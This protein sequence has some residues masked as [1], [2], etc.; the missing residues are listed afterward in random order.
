[1]KPPLVEPC[2]FAPGEE[3]ALALDC[4]EFCFH[5]IET[6]EHALFPVAFDL[7]HREFA[8]ACEMET[9]E[10]I[11]RRLE[12]S[13]LIRFS[14]STGFC[15]K[16]EMVLVTRNGTPVAARDF[17]VIRPEQPVHASVIV[18]LSHILVLP[19]C[20]GSGLAAWLRAI[21]CAL[22]RLARE[23][24]GS[25]L[26]VVLV[27]EM[28]HPDPTVPMTLRRLG[29]YR[30]AGFRK[31]DPAKIPFLQPD[32]RP[33]EEID[34]TGVH[35]LPLGLLVRFGAALCPE[36]IPTRFAREISSTLYDMY[37]LEFSAK[38]LEPVRASLKKYPPDDELVALVD[39][40]TPFTPS[41]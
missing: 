3:D 10:T 34:A 37:G 28:E 29:A 39:A 36:S 21:P 1:V 26:P 33:A 11:R 35:P 16:Y 30:K 38:H 8:P 23:S 15:A 12:R 9:L 25:S 31:L 19:E 18:H 2:D 4:K 7:L 17:T 22:A 5:R 27:A 20:R 24:A 32:F 41:P 13:A 14:E 6:A 40:L